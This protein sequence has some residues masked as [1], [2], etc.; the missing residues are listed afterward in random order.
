MNKKNLINKKIDLMNR[1]YTDVESIGGKIYVLDL[2]NNIY[3][4]LKEKSSRS[5]M[6][7]IFLDLFFLFVF[8]LIYIV[9]SYEFLPE[10]Y[11]FSSLQFNNLLFLIVSLLLYMFVDYIF[12]DNSYQQYLD[13]LYRYICIKQGDSTIIFVSKKH[14]KKLDMKFLGDMGAILSND[15]LKFIE[16]SK[17]NGSVFDDRDTMLTIKLLEQVNIARY[18]KDYKSDFSFEI[19]TDC[20]LLQSGK[21]YDLYSGKINVTKGK[22]NIEKRTTFRVY[23]VYSEN[24]KFMN[25]MIPN[26]K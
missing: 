25:G 5:G 22:E 13:L 17:V 1:Y 12:S 14:N 15:D 11:T 20:K 4:K 24:N 26:D 10:G 9:I 3:K 8:I 21:N 7:V 6:S 19:Y 16:N 2:D 18:L 23:K